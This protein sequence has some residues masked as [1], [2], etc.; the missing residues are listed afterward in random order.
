[1]FWHNHVG[2]YGSSANAHNAITIVKN[3]HRL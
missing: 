2:N 1:M 3:E